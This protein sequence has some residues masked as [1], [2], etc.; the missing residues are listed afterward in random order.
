MIRIEWQLQQQEPGIGV[1]K[2]LPWQEISVVP[3]TGWPTSAHYP[4]TT[5]IGFVVN[6]DNGLIKRG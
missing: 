6:I 4:H 2:Q 5:S 3:M 1:H